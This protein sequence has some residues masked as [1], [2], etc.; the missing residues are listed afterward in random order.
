MMDADGSGAIDAEELG[1]AFKLLGLSVNR[2]EVEAMLDEVDRDGSGEVEYA[3]FLEIMTKQLTRLA[4]QKEQQEAAAAA[5]AAAAAQ[6]LQGGEHEGAV[7]ADQQ[8]PEAPSAAAAAAAA[9]SLPFD[10]VVT[11]YRRKKLMGAL[12]EDDK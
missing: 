5:A 12:E 3:E 8:K 9:A 10:V 1:A 7:D 6:R 11:A 4:E 2:A